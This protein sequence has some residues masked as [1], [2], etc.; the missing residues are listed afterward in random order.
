MSVVHV[1]PE[2]LSRIEVVAEGRVGV[3]VDGLPFLI[4]CVPNVDKSEVALKHGR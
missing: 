1:Y 2:A 3:K 4:W